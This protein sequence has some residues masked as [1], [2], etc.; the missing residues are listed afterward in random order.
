VGLIVF[1]FA[2]FITFFPLF[3][4]IRGGMQVLTE[5]TGRQEETIVTEPHNASPQAHTGLTMAD[6]G[7]YVEA[8]EVS[9][10]KRGT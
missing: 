7:N 4:T 3:K 1:I 9:V 2:L 8:K 5:H 6:G 10:H